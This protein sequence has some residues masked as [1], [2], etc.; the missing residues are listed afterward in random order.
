ML[1]SPA[2]PAYRAAAAREAEFWARAP[3][4]EAFTSAFAL[5]RV[6]QEA[7]NRALTGNPCTTWLDDLIARGPFARAAV[8]GCTDGGAFELPWIRAGASR[9]LA[10]FELSEGVLAQLAAR[11]RG[12][13]GACAV[14]FVPADL[15]FAALPPCT[16]DVIWSSGSLH[17]ITNLEH[18]FDQVTTA[19]RPGGLFAFQ[20]YVGERRNQ[21][22]R[23]RLRLV[24]AAL[25]AV[26]APFRRTAKLVEPPP[27]AE[28]SPFCAVRSD[29]VL[30]VARGRFDAVHV[31]LAGALYPLGV[32][33]DLPALEREAPEVLRAVLRAEEQAMADPTIMPA[34]A[35][36]VFRRR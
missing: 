3:F 33:L 12:E 31:A 30:V 18:L 32:Y 24:N 29:E 11:V 1:V 17:H 22:S 15:N 34:A 4:T 7:A 2:D 25:L 28:V 26:P 21:F 27:P 20:D 35:Y 10:V 19:L 23:A 13:E 6:V 14:R 16:Y 8:L 36:A 5:S 9:V